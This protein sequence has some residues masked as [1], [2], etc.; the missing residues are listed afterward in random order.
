V[1]LL[2]STLFNLWFY[3][4][5]LLYA[6]GGTG[7]LLVG[8]RLARR[9]ARRLARFW[10]QTVLAGLRPL[11]GVRYVVTGRE[12]LPAGG[13]GLVASMHQSAFD[14]MLWM[15]LVDDPAYVLKKEL[16]ALPLFGMMCRLTRMIAVDRSAG[17]SAIRELMRGA[18]GAVA[19]GRTIVIFPEGT[20][21]PPGQIGPLQ[22]GVLALA[23][24]TRLPIIP[25]VTDSGFCW[26]RRAFRKL[27]GT[28]HVA[29]QPALPADL[30]RSAILARLDEIYRQGAVELARFPVD[31]SVDSLPG[32]LRSSRSDVL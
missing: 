2:R 28:I 6:L 24:R 12:H 14:T 29:I 8:P 19:E 3:G 31:N 20:R 18:D 16:L 5:T 32:A 17:A 25:V 11:V 21:M 1:I 7:L 30:P 26:S 9:G 15:L 27:P 4:V 23:G 22:P 10:A 13:P